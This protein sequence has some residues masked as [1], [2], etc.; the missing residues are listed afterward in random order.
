MQYGLPQK[1]AF[2]MLIFH[3]VSLVNP[4]SSFLMPVEAFALAQAVSISGPQWFVQISN[5]K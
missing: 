5:P 4:D 2:P 3:C 1:Q